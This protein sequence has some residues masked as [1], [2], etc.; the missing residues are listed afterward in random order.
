MKRWG[1]SA[2]AKTVTQASS[3]EHPRPRQGKTTHSEI[4]PICGL[5]KKT[6]SDHGHWFTAAAA[7]D[8]RYR[9]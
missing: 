1:Y 7:V 8:H 6:V 2:R 9:E 5:C 4:A 3:A